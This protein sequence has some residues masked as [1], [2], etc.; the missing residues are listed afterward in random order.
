MMRNSTTLMRNSAKIYK[1]WKKKSGNLVS[2]MSNKSNK[3]FY[4]RH[5]Q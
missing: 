4:G 3:K 2:E 1:F 5:H